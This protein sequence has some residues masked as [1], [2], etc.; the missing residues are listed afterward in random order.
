MLVCEHET[1]TV[2]AQ[3]VLV[4]W[5]SHSNKRYIGLQ[6]YISRICALRVMCYSLEPL[7]EHECWLN[8]LSHAAYT[9]NECWA[10]NTSIPQYMHLEC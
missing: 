7:T 5:V 6:A 4:V 3:A 1:C 10:I 8:V 2:L 9:H